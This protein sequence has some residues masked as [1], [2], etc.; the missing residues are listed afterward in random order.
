MEIRGSTVPLRVAVLNEVSARESSILE[1]KVRQGESTA[2]ESSYS[3]I[4]RFWE[5][6]I[7]VFQAANSRSIDP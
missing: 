1:Q 3:T 4:M 6:K 2:W 7:A 5:W